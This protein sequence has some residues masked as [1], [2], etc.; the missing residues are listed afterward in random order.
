MLHT[1]KCTDGLHKQCT[2]VELA[3]TG[4][5]LSTNNLVI[6]AHIT[7]DAYIIDS[8]LL[9]LEYANLKVERVRTDNNL[10]R[11]NL[12]H[13]I[14]VILI[15]TRDRHL[16]RIHLLADTES[17]VDR[18]LVVNITAIYREQLLQIL[19]FI[20]RVTNP[21]DIADVVFV[22][23]LYL[24]VQ[25]DTLLVDSVERVGDDMGISITLRVVEVDKQLLI[26]LIV[27]LHQ[28]S[29]LPE[30]VANLMGL[31]ECACKTLIVD[32][33]VTI[34]GN[35]ADTNAWVLDNIECHIDTLCDYS[36]VLVRG[37][38][39]AIAETLV[40]KVV[41][42]ELD[43]F[44]D[45]IVRELVTT[46]ELEFVDKVC[47]LALWNTCNLPVHYTS[48]LLEDNLQIEAIAL[49]SCTNLDVVKVTLHPEAVC[50]I[51]DEWTGQ[52]YR[53]ARNKTRCRAKNVVVEVLHAVN[54]HIA[55]VIELRILAV[56]VW[57][58]L[59]NNKVVVRILE[60]RYRSA[61][62]LNILSCAQTLSQLCASLLAL[63]AL[64][65]AVLSCYTESG[66]HQ[67]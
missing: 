9:T 54:I 14:T 53:V 47:T 52:I 33:T 26:L 2:V 15:E 29:L 20:T 40:D 34:E 50:C 48:T 62:W 25:T 43:V 24:D 6:Y 63:T 56:E 23:L 49:D 18:L 65:L 35:L 16:L 22:T 11:L 57:G 32:T 59:R 30:L 51:L 66:E 31:L 37:S 3:R 67:K 4:V 39:L 17:L 19:G 41:F 8:K 1:C 46:L 27:L 38:H 58:I 60:H 55:D 12:R 42:D 7:G 13:E 36:I 45:N 61:L 5:K 44:V 21:R 28:L 10:G 64:L